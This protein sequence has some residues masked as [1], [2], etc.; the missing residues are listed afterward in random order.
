MADPL[1]CV[2]ECVRVCGSELKEPSWSSSA[3]EPTKQKFF[4]NTN[5]CPYFVVGVVKP[6]VSLSTEPHSG[7]NQSKV[8]T[9]TD[10]D[11]LF[12]VL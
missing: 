12:L 1:L 4:V 3:S 5:S 6:T 7:H 8:D 10:T 11:T 2:R 9:H